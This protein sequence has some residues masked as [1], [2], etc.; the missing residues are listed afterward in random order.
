M[1]E[2]GVFGDDEFALEEVT[3]MRDDLVLQDALLALSSDLEISTLPI[4]SSTPKGPPKLVGALSRRNLLQYLDLCIQEALELPPG[5][6]RLF[7]PQTPLSEVLAV[8]LEHTPEQ[9]LISVSTKPV[10]SM[11]EVILVVLMDQGARVV[12]VDKEGVPLRVVTAGDVLQTLLYEDADKS[13]IQE[14]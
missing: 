10:V 9:T 3:V 5:D 14:P 1:E 2:E 4:V 11:K 8:L 13:L 12:F 6:A 7:D